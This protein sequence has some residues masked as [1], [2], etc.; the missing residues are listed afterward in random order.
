MAIM[1]IDYILTTIAIKHTEDTIHGFDPVYEIALEAAKEYIEDISRR[2]DLMWD[3]KRV[4]IRDA[5]RTFEAIEDVR[6]AKLSDAELVENRLRCDLRERLK[7][8]YE[9][10]NASKS[11]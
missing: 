4:D 10:A 2:N 7:T 3:Y 5:L 8:I 1:N 6:G 11:N 9:S